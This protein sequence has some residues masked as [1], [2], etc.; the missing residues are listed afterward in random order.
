MLERG[1]IL[2]ITDSGYIIQSLDRDG[3]I[4][5]PIG[6]E[7]LSGEDATTVS[8]D[9]SGGTIFRGS[10]YGTELT[11]TV[12][13]G[14]VQITDITGLKAKYGTNAYLSWT[15]KKSTDSEFVPVPV[16][17]ISENGFK[18]TLTAEDADEKAVYQ[19]DVNAEGHAF[20]VGDMVYYIIFSDGTGRIVC[21][22]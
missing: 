10:D 6:A 21:G 9:S 13:C 14:A 17:K 1:K 3:I 12:L 16:G 5:P 22:I 20:S 4:T 19:C 11:V 18:V 2:A 8:I 7:E 15:R